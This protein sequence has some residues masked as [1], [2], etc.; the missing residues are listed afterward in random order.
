MA[1][2]IDITSS[3]LQLQQLDLQYQSKLA[4]YETAYASY[5]S[6][7]QSQTN[8]NTYVT[9]PGKVYS[10]GTVISNTSN[11]SQTQCKTLCSANASC[12]AATFNSTSKRCSL[13]S[14]SGSIIDGATSDNLIIK[15]M[16]QQL[17]NLKT[18]NTQLIAINS[19][20]MDIIKTVGPNANTNLSNLS[21]N[22]ASLTRN[23]NAL[24][25]EQI[26]LK[27]LMDDYSEIDENYT[28][29]SLNAD[30][31]NASYN[32]WLII[33]IV[34]IALVFKFV[35]YPDATANPLSIILW[36]IIIICIVLVTTTSNNPA[37]YMIWMLLIVFVLLMKTKLIP[38]F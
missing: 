4:E 22:N 10:G 6:T 32:L 26:K 38:S 25:Q 24:T 13:F 1:N 19:Q 12:A 2:P 35:L 3:I 27:H 8:A 20:M 34:A 11:S 7:A 5:I 17:I 31:Q 18:I 23:N 16:N 21:V 37:M 28:N 14:G 36:S 9:V 33:M 15:N 30:K 29:Q